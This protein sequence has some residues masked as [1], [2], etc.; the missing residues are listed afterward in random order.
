[1]D[2]DRACR[3]EDLYR[4]I[5]LLG[6][7]LVPGTD[8][9]IY[10]ANTLDGSTASKTSA[11]WL[12]ERGEHR[13][14]APAEVSQAQPTVSPDGKTVAFLQQ[15][16]AED[17]DPWQLCTCPAGGGEVTVLTSFARG[18]GQAGP[19]WSPDGSQLA[20]D[21]SDT[22]RRDPK[23]AYRVTRKT[24][25]LDGMGLIDDR[26]TDIWVVPAEGGEP[27][28]LTSD[29]GVVSFFEWAPDGASIL[30]SSFGAA[31]QTEYAI[32]TVDTGSG[33]VR[34]VTTGPLLV[35]TAVAAWTPDGKVVYSSPWAIN[36]RIE[37]MTCDPATGIS[38]SRSPDPDG[39]L[40]G[41]MQA[42]FDSRAIQP[43]ILVDAAGEW[44]YVYVQQGGS[45]R[46]T[47]VAL[48]G[49]I[50]VEP[51]TG[52]SESV[53]P[54]ALDGSRL[55]AIRT[56]H[57]QPADL[58]VI[59]TASAGE[60]GPQPVTGLNDGWLGDLPFEVHHLSY[61]TADGRTEIEGWYLAPRDG[62][63]PYPTV[64]HIHGG[65]FAAHGEIFNLDNLLLTAAGY[66][67]LSVNFRGGSGYGD[68]HAE[69]LIGDWGRYDLADVLQGVDVA[70][71]RG[72]ADGSR[73]ASFGLSGGGYMT[74]WLLTHS[75]R[76]R[77]G[78]AECLVS[79]W[80]GMLGSDIPQVIA[81]WMDR[82]PG[83]GPESMEPYVRMAPST[84][85]A[86]CSAP[87]LVLEHEGDL[88][89]PVSQ[90]DI[91]YNEL[92]LAG[93][94][95]EMFRLPGVPHS[96][97]AADLAVRVQRAEAILEWLDRWVRHADA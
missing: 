85:A 93:K 47:R 13:R 16:G 41:L 73:V 31:D 88:R 36:K 46:T 43:R 69:M 1:V 26:Q 87:M 56:A 96:P 84:Y 6:G 23:H 50:R 18:T 38:E 68:A 22:P 35:Y 19:A 79:D 51:V 49:A 24:W 27:R 54:V 71:E 15:S 70:V 89:C 39:Q 29:D 95:T 66:G 21:A 86:A 45:L 97:F 48:R 11:L 8:A 57:T 76:F 2:S 80:A 5:D 78:I 32:C 59:D 91:L 44:A 82:Q 67:V 25:R 58:V 9:V 12:A 61:P 55:L 83:G 62:S 72:L 33:E 28:R 92:K 4:F 60:P 7:T 42:G 65:P 75:D 81:T 74:A 64:V 3:P 37:L 90:G 30:Y 14:L 63:G 77:A 52:T 94:L 20:V 10:V 17:D 40:F 34:T 53:V